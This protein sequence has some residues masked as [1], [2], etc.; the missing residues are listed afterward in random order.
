MQACVKRVG[1][2]GGYC[3]YPESDLACGVMFVLFVA[4]ADHNRY[5]GVGGDGHDE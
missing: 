3:Q 4:L 2:R 1:P 5:D